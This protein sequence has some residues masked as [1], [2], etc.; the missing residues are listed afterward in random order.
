MVYNIFNINNRGF[1]YVRGFYFKKINEVY[2]KCVINIVMTIQTISRWVFYIFQNREPLK[3]VT[4]FY[5]I[6]TNLFTL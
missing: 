1:I 4:N 5:I 2:E 6:L 3:S